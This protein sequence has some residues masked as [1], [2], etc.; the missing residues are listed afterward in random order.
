MMVNDKQKIGYVNLTTGE[1]RTEVIT[2][3]QRKFLIGARGFHMYLMYQLITARGAVTMDRYRDTL[4]FCRSEPATA[5][6]R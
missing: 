6:P 4:T 2:E 5:A 3:E 1:I